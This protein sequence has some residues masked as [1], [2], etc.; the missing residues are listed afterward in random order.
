[1]AAAHLCVKD[2]LELEGSKRK[3]KCTQNHHTSLL[4][5]RLRR[6]KCT[7]ERERKRERER[8]R[9]PFVCGSPSLRSL[10]GSK[11]P[12]QEWQLQSPSA[13]WLAGWL[14]NRGRGQPALSKE[15][16]PW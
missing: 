9:S 2:L 7:K 5:G 11:S 6:T 14:A 4:V 8:E 3:K 15:G 10:K 13:G 12:T 16:G 1:V